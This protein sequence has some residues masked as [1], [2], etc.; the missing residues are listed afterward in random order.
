MP[1]VIVPVTT[2]PTQIAPGQTLTTYYK[3][4]NITLRTLTSNSVKYLPPNVK[5]ITVALFPNTCGTTFTLAA[6]ASC[7]LGLSISGVVNG[8]DPN[9]HNHLFICTANVPACAETDYPL[10]VT[11]GSSPG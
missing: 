11:L 2:L 5:Q 8:V 10:N 6:G 3:V 4:T 9:P 7:T 1:F